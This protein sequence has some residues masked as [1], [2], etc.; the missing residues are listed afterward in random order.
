MMLLVPG[1]RLPMTLVEIDA[2]A[3]PPLAGRH[4]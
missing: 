3:G 2:D 1:D 4:G